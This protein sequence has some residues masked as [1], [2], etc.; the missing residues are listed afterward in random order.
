MEA[1]RTS[2]ESG[3]HW[4]WQGRL[5]FG[6]QPGI[7]HDGPFV[8]LTSE[9]PFTVQRIEGSAAGS[10]LTVRIEA[11]DV[12]VFAP[13][14]GHAI[15]VTRFVADPSIAEPRR[16]RRVPLPII[17]SNRM[18][19][20]AHEFT[21]AMPDDADT[22]YLG[23]QLQVDDAMAPGLLND[24]VVRR[25]GLKSH[26]HYATLGFLF[27]PDAARGAAPRR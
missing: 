22:V 4:L 10:L 15:T 8:G 3:F 16:W 13:F 27:Q 11:E 24:F 17:G 9:W 19:G 18:T 12:Q 23:L 26:S 2:V 25:L 1:L 21:V 20:D 5:H 14:D 7:R 6:D